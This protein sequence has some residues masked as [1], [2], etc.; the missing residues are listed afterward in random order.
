MV[1]LTR[2][3][4]RGGATLARLVPLARTRRCWGVDATPC[5]ELEAVESLTTEEVCELESAS[6]E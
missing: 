6:N 5:F 4:P 1:R 2:G 3:A